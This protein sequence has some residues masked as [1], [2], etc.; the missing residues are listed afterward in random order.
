MGNGGRK[1]GLF[2]RVTATSCYKNVYTLQKNGEEN[3]NFM[4]TLEM[5]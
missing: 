2:W 4:F 3:V 1:N 5:A